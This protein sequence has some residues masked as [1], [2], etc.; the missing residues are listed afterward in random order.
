MDLFNYEP[1]PAEV[2]H[3]VDHDWD[4]HLENQSNVQRAITYFDKVSI[5]K[6]WDS[7]DNACV[8]LVDNTPKEEWDSQKGSVNVV[9]HGSS[10]DSV[11]KENPPCSYKKRRHFKEEHHNAKVDDI[12]ERPECA[13]H[14]LEA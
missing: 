8:E 9:E 13:P 10:L 1:R 14:C 4:L 11:G 2:K 5:P 3:N 6:P 7:A 12:I